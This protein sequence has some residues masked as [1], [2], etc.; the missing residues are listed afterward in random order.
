MQ[1]REGQAAGVLAVLALALERLLGEAQHHAR[2]LAAGEQQRRAFERGDRLAQDEDG[3]LLEPVEMGV[4]EFGQQLLDAQRGVHARAPIIDTS[5]SSLAVLHVQSALLGVFVLPPPAPGAEVLADRD[6]ARARRAADAR[7]ELVVQRVVGHVVQLRCS[8]TR[9][10]RLQSASGL[11]L[12][13][14]PDLSFGSVSLNGT[15]ARV[16]DCSRRSPVTQALRWGEHARQ[17]LE[18]ADGAAGLAQVDR[19]VHRTFAVRAHEVHDRLG[20]R[21]VDFDRQAV[22]FLDARDQ[23]ERLVVQL[24]R[25]QRADRDAEVVARDQVGDDHV[26]GAQAGRLHDASGVFGR[27]ALQHGDGVCDA[28]VETLRRPGVEIDRAHIDAPPCTNSSALRARR[29]AV[30]GGCA[31]SG[32]LSRTSPW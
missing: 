28:A 27:G 5:A 10:P 29:S 31:N 21:L 16:F 9:R 19:F 12:M 18:L 22:P 14:P 4:V 1:Q 6:R 17:R 23:R 3:L 15:T 24:A 32:R 13:R 25:L 26:L 7:I 2:V 11:S 20:H 8:A 30:P